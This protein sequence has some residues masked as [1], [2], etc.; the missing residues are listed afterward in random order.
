MRRLHHRL[1]N[2][3]KR[4]KLVQPTQTWR[5]VLPIMGTLFGVILGAIASELRELLAGGRERRRCLNAVLFNLL[6]LRHEIRSSNPRLIIDLIHRAIAKRVGEAQATVIRE[7]AFRALLSGTFK[8][9]LKSRRRGLAERYA[10]SV[11]ALVPHEPL[12]AYRLSGEEQLLR[13]DGLLENYYSRVAQEPSVSA[14]SNAPLLISI[15]SDSTMVAA[16]DDALEHLRDA[17][18]GVGRAR[19]WWMVRCL[20][21][22]LTVRRRL[23]LQDRA[24]EEK[25]CGKLDHLVDEILSQMSDA[26]RT[27]NDATS[28]SQ[29][30]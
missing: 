9:F 17:I 20:W 29:S 10:A 5:D 8:P 2:S 19:G 16:T 3:Q 4:Q 15:A 18:L 7:P 11:Q 6:D 14:D 24:V 23:R 21:I 25:L 1:D 26:L 28:R 22:P 13:I 27:T 12:L 30:E